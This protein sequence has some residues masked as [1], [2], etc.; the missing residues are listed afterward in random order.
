HNYIV[1]VTVRGPVD[2]STGMVM[3]LG[4][5]DQA[6]ESEVLDR[7]DHTYLNLDVPNFKGKVPTTENLCVE[8]YNLLR[9]RLDSA[10]G[11]AQLAKVRLE[12]TSSNSFEYSGAA[13]TREKR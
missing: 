6:V 3:D 10:K 1:E 2:P 9:S 7:F 4:L 8:I 5:L 12:E 11:S 13:A